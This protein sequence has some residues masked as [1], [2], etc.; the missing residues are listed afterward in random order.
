MKSLLRICNPRAP[1]QLRNK[2]SDN[3]VRKKSIP[4]GFVVFGNPDKL[5][6]EAARRVHHRA[7]SLIVFGSPRRFVREAT[8]RVHRAANSRIVL[9][10]PEVLVRGRLSD[11]AGLVG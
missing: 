10:S 1:Q 2:L 5:V 7:D 8:W 4:C 11:I 6:R 3:C 9:E